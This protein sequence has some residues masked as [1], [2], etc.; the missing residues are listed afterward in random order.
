MSKVDHRN[1][2]ALAEALRLERDR[3]DTL[4]TRMGAQDKQN[5]MLAQDIVNL[6]SQVGLLLSRLGGGS[7]SGG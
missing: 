5:L 4:V 1:I 6:R 3:V 7:T 2:L